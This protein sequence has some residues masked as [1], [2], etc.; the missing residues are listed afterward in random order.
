M[1]MP[2]SVSAWLSG[3]KGVGGGG[4]SNINEDTRQMTRC[5]GAAQPSVVVAD[6][7]DTRSW[8]HDIQQL[9]RQWVPRLRP[10]SEGKGN[11][12][13]KRPPAPLHAPRVVRPVSRASGAQQQQ[14]GT[15]RLTRRA[16]PAQCWV[17]GHGP[18]PLQ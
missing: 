11:G 1:C 14:R 13:E 3:M 7:S 10:V 18:L 2:C 16:T 5:G 6:A 17:S 12:G 9:V 8:G 15:G 4:G